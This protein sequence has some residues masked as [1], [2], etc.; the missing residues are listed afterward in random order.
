MTKITFRYD[1]FYEFAWFCVNVWNPLC[2][3][4]R[5]YTEIF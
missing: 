1:T 3:F 2:S 4:L 5:F